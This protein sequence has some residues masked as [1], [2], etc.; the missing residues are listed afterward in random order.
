M[1]RQLVLTTA[2]IAGFSGF[3]LAQENIPQNLVATVSRIDPNARILDNELVIAS[4]AEIACKILNTG[5]GFS[6][7]SAED[8][9]IIAT[10]G[11]GGPEVTETVETTA[12][13]MPAGMD[14]CYWRALNDLGNPRDVAILASFFNADSG[15]VE[16]PPPPVFA[17]G[18]L[19]P[20]LLGFAE[21]EE[22]SMP[23]IGKRFGE[24]MVL[25]SQANAASQSDYYARVATLERQAAEDDAAASRA[26]L[27]DLR[28]LVTN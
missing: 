23:D 4:S 2:I 25:R 14:E 13:E 28:S 8:P 24:L 21:D 22:L 16:I 19:S 7:A 26:L 27:E 20:K 18:E 1:A 3:S 9:R 11:Y 17:S 12:L 15:L 10:A 6:V 5:L